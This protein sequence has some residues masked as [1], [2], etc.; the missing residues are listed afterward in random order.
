MSKTIYTDKAL[1]CIAMCVNPKTR[2]LTLEGTVRSSKTVSAIE[3]FFERVYYS[4]NIPI[5]Q[6]LCYENQTNL[7]Q[8]FRIC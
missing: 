4:K 7:K 1:D 8:K 5:C 6:A 3:G 2:Q